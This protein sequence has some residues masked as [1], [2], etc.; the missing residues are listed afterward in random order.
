[1]ARW[2][3]GKSMEIHDLESQEKSLKMWDVSFRKMLTIEPIATRHRSF[4]HRPS[5]SRHWVYFTHGITSGDDPPGRQQKL[6]PNRHIWSWRRWGPNSQKPVLCHQ[7]HQSWLILYGYMDIYVDKESSN[8]GILSC[9][10]SAQPSNTSVSPRFNKRL[11]VDSQKR[12][13]HVCHNEGAY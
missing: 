10:N 13:G 5:Y 11:G 9:K 8:K 4:S 7:N 3:S 6:V 1:M 12:G 2:L